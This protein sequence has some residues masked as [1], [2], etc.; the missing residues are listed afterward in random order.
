MNLL[1]LAHGEWSFRST[2]VFF[3][4]FHCVCFL[5]SL[6]HTPHSISTDR[7]LCVHAAADDELNFKV[8]QLFGP[9]LLAPSRSDTGLLFLPTRSSPRWGNFPR[10]VSFRVCLCC[11]AKSDIQR[12]TRLIFSSAE[13]VFVCEPSKGARATLARCIFLPVYYTPYTV[14]CRKK[15]PDNYCTAIT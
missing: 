7:F 9:T 12:H 10:A 11:N 8:S 4:I 5:L 6:S 14:A 13:I 15:E 1:L 2:P 3:S